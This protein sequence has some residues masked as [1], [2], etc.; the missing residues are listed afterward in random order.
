[1]YVRISAVSVEFCHAVSINEKET[2]IE[3]FTTNSLKTR[4]PPSKK[5]KAGYHSG[6]SRSGFLFPALTR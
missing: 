1:M 5:K 3:L 6:G 2:V 4:S